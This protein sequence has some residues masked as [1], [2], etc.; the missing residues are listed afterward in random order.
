MPHLLD[1][2]LALAVGLLIGTE[3]GWQVRTAAE[4]SRIAGI[5]TFGLIGLLGGLWGLLGAQLGD[6]LLGF[7]FAALTAILIFAH[8]AEQREDRDYGITTLIAALV[9]FA[10]GALAVRDFPLVAAAGAVATATLLNLKPVLHRWLL[11]LEGQE[12]QGG[13]K[14]LLISVVLLPVLPNQGYGP[15]EALNPY[16]IWWLVVLIAALSYAGYFAMKLA[17][18]HHGVMLTGLL[19]GLVS[20]T[21]VT[22]NFSRLAQH[23]DLP[24][25]LAA[26][27]LLASATM[28]SRV[29]LEIGIVNRALLPVLIAPLLIMTIAAITGVAWLWRKREHN[30][31][32][33]EMQR[34]KPLELLPAL[35]FGVLLT[36]IMLL[37]QLA[38]NNLG[39]YGI[40]V[41][42]AISGL[43][44]VDAITLSMA[45][46]AHGELDHAVA[47]RAVIIALL[48]NT[49]SKSTL[50]LLIAGRRL[51]RTLLPLMLA[52]VIAGILALLLI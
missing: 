31:V 25:V 14:L 15:G 34:P 50:I 6:V 19:G 1:L 13:L 44:D 22:L 3:R 10:L 39:E 33:E 27:I 47:G 43:A 5:R 42:A 16:E 51:S 28:F 7:A 38:H 24:K 11:Q 9:T 48:A 40:Y 26:G 49:L 36:V 4:G 30:A 17:G 35:Q 23:V 18:T 29:A 12:L 21:A 2:G 8:M 46:L 32:G 52:I 45:R 37:T 20:S 41:L